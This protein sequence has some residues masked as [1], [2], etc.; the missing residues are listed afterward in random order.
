MGRAAGKSERAAWVL[1][2]FAETA[3]YN[4]AAGRYRYDRRLG[5][6]TTYDDELDFV[7][8][9]A[10]AFPGRKPDPNLERATRRLR[11][12]LNDLVDEGLL[13]RYRQSNHEKDNRNDPAWQHVYQLTPETLE[14]V[15]GKAATAGEVIAEIGWRQ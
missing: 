11:R 8:A 14:R 1:E 13:E 7:D 10:T 12:L 15:A 3:M 4:R 9:Y 5:C 6:T 2:Y